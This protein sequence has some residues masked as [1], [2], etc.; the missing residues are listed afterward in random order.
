MPVLNENG[1][2]VVALTIAGSDSCGGAGLQADLKSFTAH[3]VY[4]A[5]V[6]T[7][8]TA[9]NFNG[10]KAI[11]LVPG[12]II[13]AQIEAVFADL[14]VRAV[15]IGMTGSAEI[16]EVIAYSLRQVFSQSDGAQI[17]CSLIVD[18]PFMS[19]TGIKLGDDETLQR[20]KSDIFPMAAL[21]TP[22][23][24]EAAVLL[25]GGRAVTIDEMKQQALALYDLGVGAVL[26]KGGHLPESSGLEQERAVDVFYD[27]TD[28]IEIGS[29]WVGISNRHGTGC[30]LS[31]AITALMARGFSLQVAVRA[32]K[33]WLTHCLK[34]S[35]EMDFS[36]GCGVLNLLN[37][38]N[39]VL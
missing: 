8:V 17:D 5:S 35:Q 36:A 38:K 23:I 39:C 4:G 15:K 34:N 6:V 33:E 10:V 22:N 2:P 37:V 29:E 21:I 13:A 7:A 1:V 20:L 32:S 18:T 25:S 24:N 16:V 19:G 27:G 3:D 28:M 31:A 12:D 26:L 11:H 14:P 9:Q 30:A